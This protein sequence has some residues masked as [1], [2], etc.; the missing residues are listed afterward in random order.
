MGCSGL[1]RPRRDCGERW[2]Q[3]GPVQPAGAGE[4]WGC[5]QGTSALV[6]GPSTRAE[7]GQAHGRPT[8][9]SHR[10]SPRRTGAVEELSQLKATA[11]DVTASL[12]QPG[13]S[14]NSLR[15]RE[16]ESLEALHQGLVTEAEDKVWL[17]LPGSWLGPG[18]GQ[19][20][21][22]E[23]GRASRHSPHFP[24]RNW[25]KTQPELCR[26]EGAGWTLSL[27]RVARDPHR[28][29]RSQEGA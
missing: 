7:D 17:V 9:W 1:A 28:A 14:A 19:A 24:S 18:S 29:R 10:T 20:G 26:G 16:A 5:T 8:K 4:G 25:H 15:G 6:S 2:V 11:S 22:V 12:G 3:I 21:R 27:Q 13:S 23:A